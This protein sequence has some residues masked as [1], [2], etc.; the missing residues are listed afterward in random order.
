MGSRHENATFPAGMGRRLELGEMM[1]TGVVDAAGEA[2]P[3]LGT[4]GAVQAQMKA[5]MARPT[6]L[7]PVERTPR[8]HRYVGLE[9][10]VS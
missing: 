2:A 10:L 7:M 8:R 6:H 5:T 9:S 4:A 1:A 3:A